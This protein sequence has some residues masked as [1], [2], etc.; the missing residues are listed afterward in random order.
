MCF[1]VAGRVSQVVSRCGLQWRKEWAMYGMLR[2]HY[3]KLVCLEWLNTWKNGCDLPLTSYRPFHHVEKW[4]FHNNACCS[5]VLTTH[6]HRVG[7]YA[8][9]PA[10][11][12]YTWE[13]QTCPGKPADPAPGFWLPPHRMPAFGFNWLWITVITVTKHLSEAFQEPHSYLYP[14]VDMKRFVSAF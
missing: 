3:H 5:S 7:S 4:K 6:S 9:E 1:I 13:R 10:L 12:L 8:P 2:C 14:S 11:E